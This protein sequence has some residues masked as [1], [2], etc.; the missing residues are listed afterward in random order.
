VF[1]MLSYKK[2]KC[3]TKLIPCKIQLGK[4]K[5][6]I[7]RKIRQKINKT[8]ISKILYWDAGNKYRFSNF[9]SSFFSDY[10]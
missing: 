2:D 6:R 1:G 7:R 9:Y 10:S 8:L 5:K 4:D 3:N